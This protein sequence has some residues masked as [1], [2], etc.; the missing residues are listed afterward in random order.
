MIFLG[1]LSTGLGTLWWNNGVHHL[2]AS[3]TALFFNGVPVVG[4]IGA[5]LFFHEQLLLSHILA[6]LL[7]LAGIS[8]GSGFFG[9]KKPGNTSR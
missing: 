5:I 2:G 4:V 7:V 9:S 6:L 8:L 1:A 3:T